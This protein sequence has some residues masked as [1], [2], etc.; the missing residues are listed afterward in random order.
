MSV[1]LAVLAPLM[2]LAA[3]LLVGNGLVSLD[4]GLDVL[5]LKIAL[6]TSFV[7][8]AFALGSF[9]LSLGQFQRLGAASLAVLVVCAAISGLFVWQARALAVAGPSDVSTNLTDPPALPGKAGP[10]VP[11][12]GVVAI[13]RQVALEAASYVLVE[14]GFAIE[15]VQR[16]S[17]RGVK[18]GFWFG[19]DQEAVIRIRPG[20]T[21]VRV[22]ARHDRPDGGATCELARALI[23]GLQ[24]ER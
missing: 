20:A 3:V 7:A 2:V 12:A 5:T 4:F 16:F 13:P 24:T 11:C 18:P 8:L 22:A 15:D 23:A 6:W 21:D 17:V 19:L 10:P 14:T 9:V 1:A